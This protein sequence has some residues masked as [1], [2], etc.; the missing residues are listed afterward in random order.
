MVSR[1][2]I[3]EG[4]V[5]SGEGI[6]KSIWGWE[7]RGEERSKAPERESYRGRA[8]SANCGGAWDGKII[9]AG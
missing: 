1:L 3:F 8:C 9:W 4:I 2:A 5:R 7:E 6:E